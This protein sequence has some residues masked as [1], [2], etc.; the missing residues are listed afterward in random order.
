ML[1]QLLYIVAPQNLGDALASMHR[2]GAKPIASTSNHSHGFRLSHRRLK[3]LSLEITM[4]TSLDDLAEHLR[5]YPVDLLVYDERFG[6]GDAIDAVTRIRSEVQSVADHWGP[7][8]Y[9]PASRIVVIL[10]EDDQTS[11]RLFQLGRLEIRDILVNPDSTARLLKWIFDVLYG[12][13][14]RENRVGLALSGGGLDGFLYQIGV[15]HALNQAL[16]DR[17]LYEVDIISGVSSGALAGTVIASHMA[18]PE[19]IRSINGC[20]EVLPNFKSKTLMDFAAGAISKRLIRESLNWRPHPTQ[21][22]SQLAR[23]IPTGFFQGEK[24]E[25]YLQKML[26]AAH[27]EDRFDRLKALLYIGATDQDTFEHIIF[28]EK[29]RNKMKVSEACRASCAFPMFFAP[30]TILGRHYIDGQVT[31][32]CNLDIA[33]HKGARL[34]FVVDPLKPNTRYQAGAIEDEGG[35]FALVQVIKALCST[36]FEAN[37]RHVSA[38]YP[39]VDFITFQPGEECAALMSGSPMNYK[40]KTQLIEMAYRETIRKLRSRHHVYQSKMA[41]YGFYLASTE[42]LTKLEGT[43]D[44][45]FTAPN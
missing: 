36:R 5:Q 8:F 12:G 21:W 18:I 35:Y 20:S 29:G 34:L 4:L 6:G 45:V 41:R 43:Y 26:A 22:L 11:H 25:I 23:L 14:V 13:V 38:R 40:I 32:S 27:Q 10:N 3:H 39:D 17:D 2:L 15:L 7:D 16:K 31:R 30:K 19:V 44:A 42:R 28:G 1:Q 33:I 37:L 9:F 24:L